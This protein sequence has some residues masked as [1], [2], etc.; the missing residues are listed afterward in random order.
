[1]KKAI[2]ILL[3]LMICFGMCACKKT[4]DDVRND[5]VKGTWGTNQESA[6]GTKDSFY[7]FSD[8]GTYKY[9]EWSTWRIG[10]P[11]GTTELTYSETGTYTIKEDTI[12]CY[13]KSVNGSGK[14]EIYYSYEWGKLVLSQERYDFET[15]SRRMMTLE[16][17]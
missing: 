11:N 17:N 16:H 3:V 6:L 1:M 8:D 12:T 5:L 2:A 9:E 4:A 13:Y 10:K 15:E 14:S 7:N